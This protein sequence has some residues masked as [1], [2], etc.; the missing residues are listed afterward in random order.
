MHLTD[1]LTKLAEMHERGQLSDQEFLQAKKR[2]LA[3]AP[4]QVASTVSPPRTL[5][6]PPP[7]PATQTFAAAQS[8]ATD[9]PDNDRVFHSSRWSSGNSFFRDRVTA[10]A[11]GITFRK[12]AMFGSAEEHISYRSIASFKVD[13]GVFLSNITIETAGGSQPIF[14]NGLWKSDAKA[15]QEIIRRYQAAGSDK[16]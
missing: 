8:A 3:E 11:D 7:R 2:L 14:I 1:E 5:D 9:K 4:S 16:L 12:G 13:H 6:A 15:L 10:A